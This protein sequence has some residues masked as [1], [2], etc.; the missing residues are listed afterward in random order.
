MSTGRRQLAWRVIIV[1]AQL[2][3]VGVGVFIAWPT[4]RQEFRAAPGDTSTAPVAISTV[5]SVGQAPPSAVDIRA[6]DAAQTEAKPVAS[7][8]SAAPI[9]AAPPLSSTGVAAGGPTPTPMLPPV[10]ASDAQA[11]AAAP[12]GSRMHVVEGGDTLNKIA[13][14]YGV[15]VEALREANGLGDRARVLRIG[16][17]LVI[18]DSP[19]ESPP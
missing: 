6:S 17:R 13:Q 2:I 4:T 14:R 12:G 18:P 19:P 16:E 11:A 5:G 9:A 15:T 10:P 3:V 7:P 1:A 8:T